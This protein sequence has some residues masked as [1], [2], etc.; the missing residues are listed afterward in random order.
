M[1]MQDTPECLEADLMT[2]VL[3]R[4]TKVDV[5]LALCA[6]IFAVAAGAMAAPL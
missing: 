5:L 4:C 3:A 2:R 1:Q 6:G